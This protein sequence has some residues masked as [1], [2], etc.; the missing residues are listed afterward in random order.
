MALLF[1]DG[2][3]AG[4]YSLKFDQTTTSLIGTSTTTRFSVG[5]S[6]TMNKSIGNSGG[7]ARKFITPSNVVV[8]GFAFRTAQLTQNFCQVYGDNGLTSHINFKLQSNGALLVYRGGTNIATSVAG[9]I[10]IN[11]WYYMEYKISIDDVAGQ[12]IVRLDGQ[13][14]VNFTG[15]TKNGGT[16]NTV[17]TV[18]LNASGSDSAEFIDD[19]YICNDTGTAPYNDFLGDVR[20]QTLVPDGAGSSTQFTPSAGANYTTVDEL[21]YSATDYVSSTTVGNRDTYSVTDLTGS[22]TIYGIQNNVI[23]KKTDAGLIS[24]KPAI[25]SGASVYY[26]GTTVLNAS[27]KT[28]TDTRSIDPNTSTGWTASG[29]NALESGFEVA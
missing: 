5:R 13:T 24:I 17:D 12:V 15:D 27:D 8:F 19:F 9:L 16:A 3:D 7:Y 14:I 26:G 1:M 10:G 28:I 23:A 4:D 2:F 25:K 20:V 11:N 21:P 18:E 29:V 6:L 22:P